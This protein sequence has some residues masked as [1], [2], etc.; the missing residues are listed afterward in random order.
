MVYFT[1]KIS[2]LEDSS[3]SETK[4]NSKA[5]PVRKVPAK[6][7]S[8]R[9]PQQVLKDCLSKPEWLE[10]LTELQRSALHKKAEVLKELTPAC[11]C[12][13]PDPPENG[14]YYVHLGHAQS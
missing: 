5:L 3:D 4:A 12:L 10:N 11:D 8:C 2:A 7:E 6:K 9:T 13:G 1:D 14:P